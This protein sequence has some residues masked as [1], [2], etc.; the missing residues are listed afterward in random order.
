MT[1]EG[2]ENKTKDSSQTTDTRVKD[3]DGIRYVPESD[4]L[5]VKGSLT[6]QRDARET[7]LTEA[8]R[9]LD[10]VQNELNDLKAKGEL[11]RADETTLGSTQKRIFDQMTSVKKLEDSLKEKEKTLTTREGSIRTKELEV[12]RLTLATKYGIDAE[13]LKEHSDPKD[14]EIAALRL[15][16]ERGGKPAPV[17]TKSGLAPSGSPGSTGGEN[18]L[19]AALEM[20]KAAKIASGK[21]I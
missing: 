14:M 13:V 3:I 17:P 18:R 19:Q 2:E 20:V 7:E 12:S 21:Q 6:R 5:A 4:L 1:K 8:K 11:L 10:S 16:A 15:L 9:T